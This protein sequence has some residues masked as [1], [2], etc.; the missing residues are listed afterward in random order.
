MHLWRWSEEVDDDVN[1]GD[2]YPKL[3]FGTKQAF[4]IIYV[5][6]VLINRSDYEHNSRYLKEMKTW[7]IALSL[8]LSFFHSEKKNKWMKILKYHKRTK[9]STTKATKLKLLDH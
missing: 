2:A 3:H 1:D 8:S 7:W 6:H 4:Y 9:K 5:S